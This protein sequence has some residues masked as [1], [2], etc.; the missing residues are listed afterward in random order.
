MLN[1]S[2]IQTQHTKLLFLGSDYAESGDKDRTF[3]AFKQMLLIIL[4]F[5]C[6]YAPQE[7]PL[8]ELLK[9]KTEN[10]ETLISGNHTTGGSPLLLHT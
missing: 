4:V 10:D 2:I 9:V 1:C 3:F 7:L 6:Y 8:G 5:V